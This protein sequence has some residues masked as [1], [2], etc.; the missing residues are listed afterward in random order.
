MIIFIDGKKFGIESKKTILE[1]ARENEIY[2]PSLC[3]HSRL[4]PFSGCRL[5][6][7]EIKGR[8]GYVPSCSTYVEEGM[9]VKTD[10]PRLRKMRKQIL[11]LILSEHPNA[12]LIC[13]EKEN[14]DEYKSTIR[15]VGEVTGCV[16]C[17]NNGRCELQ[18][19]VKA[20]K[21]DKVRF[22]SVYRNYEVK[23]NDPFFDRNYN[24]CILCGRC[25]RVCHDLRGSSAVSF[26]FRGS[27][28]GIGTVF[29]Q[30]LLEAGCQFCGACVDVCPTGALT[31]RALKYETLPDETRKTICPFCSIGCELKME[32]KEGRILNSAPSEDGPVNQGQACVKGR[33]TIKDAVYS[34]QRILKPM[35]RKNKELEEVS[36][37]EAL[38]FVAK[39]LKKY[40]GK[41]IGLIA[42]P[43]V[44]NEDNFLIHK[45]AEYVLKTENIDSVVRF[46]SY[47]VFQDLAQKNGFE[48]NLNFKI[49]DISKAKTIFLLGADIV[50]THPI[51]WLEVLR[52]VNNGAKLIVA[53]SVDF[54]LNRFSSLWLKMKP[55]SEY[56]LLS[57]L[58]K[59]IIDKSKVENLA[60]I[61]GFKN[62]KSS[63]DELDLSQAI[64][65]T[66]IEEE[67]IKKA[68][69]ILIKETPS[70]FIFGMELTQLPW[71]SQNLAGLWNLSLQTQGQLVP[72]GLET[73]LRGLFEL[74]RH[75]SSNTKGFK[76][77]IQD[78]EEGKV[79]AL[80][81]AS[82]IPYSQKAKFEFLVI[83]DSF[84]SENMKKADAVLPAASFAEIEGT[85]VNVEGRIQKFNKVIEPL[86]EAKPDWWIIS[87]LAQKMGHNELNY[88]ASSEI[89]KEMIKNIPG[90]SGISF[91]KL[92]KGERLF[93]QEEKKGK[94]KFVP[95]KFFSTS[96]E[97]SKEY[98]FLMLVDYNLDY[99]KNLD[100]SQEIKAFGIIR[101]SRWFKINPN[102][103]KKTKLKD[104]E[105][106]EV[107]SSKGKVKGIVKVLESVPRGTIVASF[108]WNEE[109]TI[110]VARLVSPLSNASHSLVLLP[111]KIKR[112]K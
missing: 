22:P 42:S 12:C 15:K 36:W 48:L 16:L 10:S 93:I 86:G 40:K 5:C 43:Q 3:D 102:D 84:M 108:L 32:L 2:I 80:Y 79:K 76:R 44:S 30:T 25:V 78:A 7:V 59:V 66:D 39:K 56:F 38:D 24:L 99:Y 65:K 37:E 61:E 107:E 95:I 88:N 1:A 68:A 77:I 9:D 20:L 55:G 52:A 17:P 47:A 21:I 111:V 23:K 110:S 63:L 57:F 74:N 60:Q 92:K 19:V 101:N 109:E 62:L 53:S 104:G 98:P 58:S 67:N 70:V 69:E 96:I 82:P 26:V 6:I 112:G 49:E 31:E 11:E 106:M 18:D 4:S 34:S 89:S 27:K 100:L 72:L 83:Q 29:D 94:K 54:F 64:E 41:E 35:I 33:F 97:T 75:C 90:F 13:S 8:R 51:I 103:A 105:T 14:C 50:V 81:L 73:N 46:S 28:A 45:F 71:G 91:Q 85:F 87:Q